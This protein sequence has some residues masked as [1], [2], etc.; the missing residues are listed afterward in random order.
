M[1]KLLLPVLLCVFTTL[2]A[3]CDTIIKCDTIYCFDSTCVEYAF[4]PAKIE[5]TTIAN[6]KMEYAIQYL[7]TT[8][9]TA[10]FPEI[11]GYSG[12]VIKEGEYY[13]YVVFMR[14]SKTAQASIEDI[15]KFY[16]DSFV[17]KM[18]K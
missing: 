3:Q 1:Q 17:R 7:S 14:D 15:R 2:G 18:P 6:V 12:Q 9:M 16:P 5:A 4:R 11:E 10:K 8:S 13:R